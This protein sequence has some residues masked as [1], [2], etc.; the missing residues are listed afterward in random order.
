MSKENGDVK[1]FIRREV[2]SVI[3]DETMKELQERL[4][5]MLPPKNLSKICD[6]IRL[7]HDAARGSVQTYKTRYGIYRHF[8]Y[9]PSVIRAGFALIERDYT[10]DGLSARIGYSRHQTKRALEAL[11]KV[12]FAVRKWDKN[13]WQRWIYSI[14]QEKC[15]LLYWLTRTKR[16]TIIT[17]S[18]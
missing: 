12:E 1:D 15:P 6:E 10:I 7:I 14:N 13:Y 5:Q 8:R 11:E 17:G 16:V 3:V 9:T 18:A 2:A 4:D